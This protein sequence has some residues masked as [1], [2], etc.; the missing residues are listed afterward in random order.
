VGLSPSLRFLNVGD[1]EVCLYM[2][3]IT[4]IQINIQNYAKEYKEEKVM[5]FSD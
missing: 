1:S 3:K 2:K 5:K 4:A